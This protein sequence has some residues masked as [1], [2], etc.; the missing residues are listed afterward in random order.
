MTIKGSC[1]CGATAFEIDGDI[2]AQL[3]RCNCSFCARPGALTAAYIP[4]QFR[5]TPAPAGESAYRW[6]ARMV[7]HHF[8]PTCGCATYS[9]S[10]DFQR[11]GSWD[12]TTRRIVVKARLFSDFDAAEADVAL[13]D[14][15]HLW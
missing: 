14:G 15:K 13:I 6:Q 4:A 7:L 9:D 1:H 10:P 3:T 8:C 12:G 5:L 2:P 11:D